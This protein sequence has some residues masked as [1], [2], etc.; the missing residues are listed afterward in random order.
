MTDANYHVIQR[1]DGSFTIEVTGTDVPPRAATGFATETG[2][3]AW[4]VQD[5]RHW[6]AGGPVRTPAYR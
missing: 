1:N 6:E 3:D 2:A 4:T 5:K